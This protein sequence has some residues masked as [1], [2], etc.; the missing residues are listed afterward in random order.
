MAGGLKYTLKWVLFAWSQDPISPNL[1]AL[2]EEILVLLQI[3][4]YLEGQTFWI[5]WDEIIHQQLS[6]HI[7]IYIYIYII[8]YMAAPQPTLGQYWAE[9]LTHLMLITVFW[10]CFTRGSPGLMWLGSRSLVEQLM[11]FKP[12]TFQSIQ[13][14]S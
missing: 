14:H 6:V 8:C 2:M 11:G 5:K 7:Y 12:G 4:T 10:L 1:G 9:S 13:N 3:L